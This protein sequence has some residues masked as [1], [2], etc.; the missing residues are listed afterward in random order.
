VRAAVLFVATIPLATWLET[1]LAGHP[2]LAS[3]VPWPLARA[4]A[5][6]FVAVA[7]WIAGGELL[8]RR[9]IA[10]AY[11]AGLWF[12]GAV[13]LASLLGFEPIAGSAAALIFGAVALAGNA[14]FRC[15]AG[16]AWRPLVGAWL[17]SGLGACALALI[18]LAARRPASLYAFA[19]GRAIGI[20]ENPNE[21]AL[22][23]LGV[24][25][26]AIAGL[27]GGYEGRRLAIAALGV[28]MLTLVATGSRSGEAAFGI[29][30]IGLAAALRPKRVHLAAIVA[31]AVLAIGLGL[32]VDRRHNP[33]DN[34]IRIAAWQAG[35]RAVA[36]FPLTG[37]GVGA[38]HRV[39]PFLRSPDAP[40][41]DDP[42]AFDPHSFYLS[43]A[44]ETGLLGL[45][46]FVWTIAVF[47]REARDAL[48]RTTP[49]ARRFG[50]ALSAGLLA[51]GCH[52]LLNAFA[53]AIVLWSFLAALTLGVARSGYG[54]VP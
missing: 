13:L 6:L 29:G 1:A 10:P 15:A 21:L 23:A 54:R 16:G 18:A 17:W 40:G 2:A 30:A 3:L 36:M 42:I 34:D 22:F 38:Y 8:T 20:F 12:A 45:G 9:P 11:R 24:C 19:H 37:V 31:A 50:L 49:Q 46:A 14:L 43:V 51:I 53:S 32:W 35:A 26:A 25:A 52:L 47:I 44:A 27:L 41:A 7:V 4:G 28:G 48:A 33:A 39:Y 5:A